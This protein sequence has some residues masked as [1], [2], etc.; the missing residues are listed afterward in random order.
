MMMMVGKVVLVLNFRKE[1]KSRSTDSSDER[2]SN[3]IAQGRRLSIRRRQERHPGRQVGPL[4]QLSLY[5]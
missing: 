4:A 1:S 5:F 2:A 3:S